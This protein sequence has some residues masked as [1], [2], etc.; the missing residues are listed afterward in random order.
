M[1]EMFDKRSNKERIGHLNKSET[2]YHLKEAEEFLF[3]TLKRFGNKVA[4]SYDVIANEIPYFKTLNYTEWA[5]CLMVHPLQQ[6]LRLKQVTD[7][8]ND[9]AEIK[10]DF[11]EY[12]RNKVLNGTNN[13]YDHIPK[14]LDPDTVY[15]KNLVVLVGSNK[16]KERVCLNKLKWIKTNYDGEVFFKPHPIT[17]HQFVGELKDLFGSDTVLDRDS[18]MYAY[19][20]RA[21]TVFTTHMTESA[22]Y[23][24]CLDKTIEPIDV[25]HKAE[26]GSFYHI[27]KFLFTES[28]PKVWLNRVLNSHK[29]G[30]FNP[31]IELHWKD[32]LE[33]YIEYILQTRDSFKNKYITK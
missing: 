30:V 20:L 12:F 22:T 23:A 14:E 15:R 29:C 5:H 16:L 26:Q 24:I 8:Y 28:E 25:Y 9:N 3:R 31:E 11:I 13:K 4:I 7:A 18:N 10:T 33:S 19:M 1:M 32:K 6:E 27:N 17:T 2:L 21:D